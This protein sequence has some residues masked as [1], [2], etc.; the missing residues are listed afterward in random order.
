MMD[1]NGDDEE[2][3]DVAKSSVRLVARKA[4]PTTEPSDSEP[5]KVPGKKVGLLD[6][7]RETCRNRAAPSASV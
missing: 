5:L 6:L 2:A 3:L 1:F 7:M 4:G